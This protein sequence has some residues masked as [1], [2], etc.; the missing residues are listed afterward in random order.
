MHALLF[1]GS[2]G[3][4]LFVYIQTIQSY[5]APPITMVFGLGILWTGLTAHGALAG[6]IIGFVMGM[7]K[8][9]V[10]NVYPVPS[11]G[12]VDDRPG[13]AKMHFMFYGEELKKIRITFMTN[14]RNDNVTMFILHLPLT[15]F[16]LRNLS[17]TAVPLF[18]ACLD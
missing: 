9:I 18:S 17:V 14:G 16:S 1:P 11:C 2:A 3:T 8:F 10:G 12:E 13:F 15:V 7:A 4:Q 6:L 5:L